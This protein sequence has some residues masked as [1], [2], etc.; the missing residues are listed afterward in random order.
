MSFLLQ[1]QEGMSSFSETR[2]EGKKG[3]TLSRAGEAACC[4][5]AVIFIFFF[6]QFLE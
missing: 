5:S 1:L 3:F 6:R 4:L 2:R